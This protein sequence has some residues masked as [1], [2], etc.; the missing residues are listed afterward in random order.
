VSHVT[1]AVRDIDVTAPAAGRCLRVVLLGFYNYSSQALRLFHP[2]LERRGHEVHS[3][4]FKDWF[5]Y[6]RPT[7]REEDMV[8]ERI[9]ALRPDLVAVQV[10]STYYQL[11][12]RLSRRIKERTG[13]TIVWGGIHAQVCPEDS[14]QYADVVARSEGE[15][16]LAEL[17]DRIGEGKAFSD[18]RGAWV[19]QDGEI[20]QNEPHLLIQDLDSLPLP[21]IGAENTHCLGAD[22]WIDADGWARLRRSYDIMMVRGCPF[23][24]TFC[25]HNYTRKVSVGLGKYVRRR[26]V[27][28]CLRELRAACELL[29]N[30]RVIAFDDD[31]FAPPR[32]WL[33]EFCAR[34]RE[35]IGL[36]FIMY[37]FPGMVD[38]AK[39]RLMR[40]AG[41]FATTMGIQSGSARIRRDC[42]E[43]ATPNQAIIDACTV[44]ERHGVARNLDFIGDNPYE[45]E[46]DRRET[47]QLLLDLPKP[48]YF[49][50]FSLT[51]FP[52]VDLTA[53]AVRDGWITREDVEDVAEKGYLLYGG[54]FSPLRSPA[55]LRWDVS[56]MMAVYRC[57]R[58]I[59]WW[60]LDSPLL[61]THLVLAIRFLKWLRRMTQTRDRVLYRLT[62]RLVIP[63][64]S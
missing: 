45:N 16:L 53:R 41:L 58:R 50:Y 51:Y 52:G 28:H 13:A 7:G 37:S 40:S 61:M 43:R 62:G 38:E 19:H 17:T 5:T 44:F 30:L 57:P 18:L 26:S 27:D 6:V 46:A 24:C 21:H 20:L 39:V 31:I 48:F 47:L 1:V 8:V 2:L 42:Y 64:A 4:F 56:Y 35:E 63:S 12:A 60:L 54:A 32:P 33:E 23:E 22:G 15:Y 36:P 25:I 34:Y 10:W 3:V 29:P 9:E 49:N 55:E 11:A 14:L 59:V